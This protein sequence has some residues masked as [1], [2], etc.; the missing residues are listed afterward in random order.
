MRRIENRRL[1]YLAPAGVAGVVALASAI[2]SF[3]AGSSPSNLPPI[4]AQA[5]IARVEQANVPA[6]QGTVQ[7]TANLGL[8][9]LSSLTSG[10][11]GQVASTTGFNPTSLLSGTHDINVWSNQDSQRLSLPA[12]MSETD[13]VRV[14]DQA[15]L[16]DSTNQHVTHYVSA[17][18]PAG[19]QPST[20]GPA[21]GPAAT[22]LTPD[23]QA[24]K[25]LANLN[26]STQV[27]AASGNDVAGQ[28]TYV[29][30]LSPQPGS[31]A[32]SESTLER[33]TISVDANNGLPLAV[34]VYAAGT[35]DPVLSLG[36]TSVSFTAPAASNFE[37]PVGTSTSTTTVNPPEH[38]ASTSSPSSGG[39][40]NGTSVSG[41]PWAWVL[42]A[43]SGSAGGGS[44]RVL[45]SSAVQGAT[46]PVNGSFGNGRLLHTSVINVL[47]L[48]SGA[49]L[50]GFVTP[51]AL[52]A[53]A[54]A[55]VGG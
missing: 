33:A 28:P 19:S 9:D 30:T 34:A 39:S 24:A 12:G 14:G 2:P 50:A 1:R 27:T 22:P 46:T 26:P 47:F 37:A 45:Y 13:L 7:W 4:T 18:K 35:T 42:S 44:D 32:A 40:S 41:Q 51:A 21:P 20:T 29:L 8:P 23:Q 48:P 17:Q 3:A 6:L 53:Q 15:W 11:D 25:I 49:I 10:S 31:K 55:P 16:Y 36:F 52:E 38:H 54:A 43:P 5:L